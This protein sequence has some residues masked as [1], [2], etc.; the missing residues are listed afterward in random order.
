MKKIIHIVIF[1]ILLCNTTF[2][3]AQ[4]EPED[5]ALDKNDF[6][7]SYYDAIIQKSIENFDKALQSLDKCLKLQPNNA[8]IH[9]EMGKNY[10]FRKDYANAETSYTKAT[11]IDPSN[12]WY[13]IDL[14]DLYYETKNYNQAILVA[15]KIIPLDKNYKEDLVSMYMYTQQYEKA[16][17]LINDIEQTNGKTEFMERYKRDI[18][19]QTKNQ[20]SGKNDLEKAI[21]QSPQI[22]ENY[23]SLI[24]MYSDNKQ[25]EKAKL[26]AEKLEK[27]IPNSDWAQ[28]FL[29]KYHLNDNKGEEA[30][31]SL[32]TVLKSNKVD[33]KIKFKMFNEF[34]IFTI[35]N[36]IFEPQLNTATTFFESDTE[37]DVYKEV[38]KFY[39]KKKNWEQAIKN[40]EKST[41]DDLESNL[42]L[43]SSIE[44]MAN[45][46][47]LLAKASDL[48][49]TYPNQPQYYFFAGKASNKLKLYKKATDLLESGLEFVID[50]VNL[51]IDFLNQLAEASKGIGNIKKADEYLAKANNLKSKTK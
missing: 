36:P 3:L 23:L 38:G 43:L 27:N 50:N 30:S 41:N 5:I 21:E 7:D 13:L 39:Y 26:I 35:K 25:E 15:Q 28:V 33:K 49:D 44:E 16:L 4:T 9:H 31:K 48:V 32:Q 24:Y 6:E 14:Y 12:K 17:V 46:D 20:S 51:E 18:L 22:E 37:F 11:Q 29:F 40:L 10:F 47:K 1:A 34:L 8:V 2:V 19:T 45:T 42:F